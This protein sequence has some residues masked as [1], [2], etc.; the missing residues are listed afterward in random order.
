[1][2]DF[3]RPKPWFISLFE[4][5]RELAEFKKQP[6]MQVSFRPMTEQELL[7]SEDLGLRQMAEMQQEK[8]FLSSFR[9]NLRGLFKPEKLPPLQL[10]SRPLTKEE[11]QALTLSQLEASALP[12]YRNVVVNLKDLLFPK[13]LPPLEITS[14]PVQV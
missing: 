8:G 14:R 1:M 6:P 12:W 10:T 2:L 3:Q 5:L 7:N 13:K 11:Q 9:E 4:T